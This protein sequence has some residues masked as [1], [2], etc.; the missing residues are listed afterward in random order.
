[1]VINYLGPREQEERDCQI[2]KEQCQFSSVAPDFYVSCENDD[3]IC[4]G[5]GGE[6]ILCEG[7]SP[8]PEEMKFCTAKMP[9]I[10]DLREKQKPW[11]L[12]SDEC[13][14]GCKLHF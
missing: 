3:T 12:C 1:M 6:I 14:N 2:I 8:D 13:F 7:D 11:V 10:N 9:D 5:G 4:S